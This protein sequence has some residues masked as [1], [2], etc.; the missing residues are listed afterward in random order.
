MAV[1]TQ[2]MGGLSRDPPPFGRFT[3]AVG[4]YVAV[5]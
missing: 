3:S 2:R 1:N 5:Y 4:P